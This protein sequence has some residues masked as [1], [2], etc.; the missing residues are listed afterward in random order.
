MRRIA[1]MIQGGVSCNAKANEMRKTNYD[2]KYCHE[3]LYSVVYASE[4]V[5]Q[6]RVSNEGT[7]PDSLSGTKKMSS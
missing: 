1:K 4:S 3:L 5:E 2:A 6:E 7:D